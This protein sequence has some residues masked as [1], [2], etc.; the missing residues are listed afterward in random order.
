MGTDGH[1][2]EM[3][4]A[5]RGK[6]MFIF[7]RLLL[8]NYDLINPHHSVIHPRMAEIPPLAHAVG[9]TIRNRRFRD[10]L[11]CWIENP[12]LSMDTVDRLL[13]LLKNLVS[14]GIFGLTL[15]LESDAEAEALQDFRDYFTFQILHP[16]SK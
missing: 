5:V 14:N 6:V 7:P 4:D 2:F 8:C 10:R 11:E 16:C 1:R 13:Y 15:E 12:D 9:L 3:F